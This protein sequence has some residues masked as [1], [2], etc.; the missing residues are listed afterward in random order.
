MPTMMLCQHANE[1][2]RGEC[3]CPLDCACRET[4]CSTY[5]KEPIGG[6]PV[7]GRID[8][9]PTKLG[10][11]K[12]TFDDGTYMIVDLFLHP[13]DGEITFRGVREDEQG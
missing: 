6:E 3:D 1:V 4:M 7:L 5:T 13:Y 11:K 10:R 2:P 12:I 9:N 8:F